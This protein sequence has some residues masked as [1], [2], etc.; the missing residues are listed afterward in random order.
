MRSGYVYVP[1]SSLESVIEQSKEAY[2]IA[3]RRTQGTIRNDTPEW[4]AW[5]LYFLRALQKQKQRLEKKIA[6]E[7]IVIDTLPE[8]S[9]QILELAKEHGKLTN[10][11]IVS[12]T[13]AN[14]NTIKKHLQ[15]LVLANHL[16]QHG[17]GKGTWY[18]RS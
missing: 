13:G 7:K 12:M 15:S 16:T 18:S 4:E 11:Q 10:S 6:R 3:L 14:R 1:Y 17:E 5:V 2:Y 9:V 8:L